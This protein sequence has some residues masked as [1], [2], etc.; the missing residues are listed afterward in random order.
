M[1]DRLDGLRRRA[2]AIAVPITVLLRAP[3]RTHPPFR[4]SLDLIADVSSA[5][6]KIVVVSTIEPS[7]EGVDIR[8]QRGGEV[9]PVSFWGVPSGFELEG[10]VYALECW[11]DPLQAV[12]PNLDLDLLRQIP[13]RIRSD[14]YVAPT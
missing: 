12:L 5:T 10:F 6:T 1:N 14:L 8:I 3:S 11:A 4:A 2:A 9:G 7:A 13:R